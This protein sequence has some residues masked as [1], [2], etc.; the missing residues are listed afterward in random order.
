MRPTGQRAIVVMLLAFL[1]V[2]VTVGALWTPFGL[3]LALALAVG[4]GYA[5]GQW[6]ALVVPLVSPPLE[7]AI[8]GAGEYFS[9]WIAFALFVALPLTALGVGL[10]KAVEARAG[11]AERRREVEARR[12][13]IEEQRTMEAKRRARTQHL[14]K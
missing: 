12:R 3:L 9:L 14:A 4:V 2:A 1:Y 7:A 13:F 10:R 6:W 5:A 8:H 11:R